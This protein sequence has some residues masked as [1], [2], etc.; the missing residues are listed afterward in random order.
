MLESVIEL[1]HVSIL[2]VEDGTVHRGESSE[3]LD[4]LGN[5][6]G[7]VL[8]ENGP[9]EA[10]AVESLLEHDLVGDKTRLTAEHRSSLHVFLVA[11][12][13]E[14][15]GLQQGS[16]LVAIALLEEF[17]GSRLEESE[18]AVL[19]SAQLLDGSLRRRLNDVLGLRHTNLA[20][21]EA[22]LSRDLL[23]ERLLLHVPEGDAGALLTSS[24]RSTGTMNISFDILWGLDLN[25][26]VDVGNVETA[27]CNV[28][29]NEHLELLLL[30]SLEGDLTLSLSNVTVHDL[31]I[32]LDLVGQDQLVGFCL[33]LTEDNGLAETTVDE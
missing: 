31:K 16:A 17:V 6:L 15:E 10:G 14:S 9:D 24:S 18:H 27:R 28:G 22:S 20:E 8:S 23:N 19:D 32:L 7:D 29:R 3:A 2:N 33:G 21:L 30:E 5:G 13:D 4:L 11:A 12:R 25:N 1:L 26:Q